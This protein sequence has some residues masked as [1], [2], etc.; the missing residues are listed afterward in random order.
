MNFEIQQRPSNSV[1]SIG[2]QPGE[3]LTAEGG[4]MMALSGGIDM[5]TSTRKRPGGKGGLKAGL[6][7]LFSGES[8]FLNHYTA[9]EEGRVWLAPTLIGDLQVFQIQNERPLFLQG[10]SYVANGPGIDIELSYQGLKSFVGGEGLFWM[11]VTGQG[12]VLISSFGEIYER[13]VK[14]SFIVDSGHVVA[15]DQSLSFKLS[16]VGGSWISSF[17]GGE[18]FVMKFEGEGKVWCQ[19]HNPGSFG[20]ALGPKLRAR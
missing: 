19:S 16:K 3:V 5:E 18:G 10:G 13:E 14:G 2:L 6:K 4:S 15:F 11:K 1:A 7:R 20:S 12:D 8:Y 9:R 17:L